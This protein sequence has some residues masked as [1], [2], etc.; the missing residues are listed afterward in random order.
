M[1]KTE[2]FIKFIALL[3]NKPREMMQAEYEKIGSQGDPDSLASADITNSVLGLWISR[4]NR[5]PSNP[6][7]TWLEKSSAPLITPNTTMNPPAYQST[8]LTRTKSET[9]LTYLT[10]KSIDVSYYHP[11]LY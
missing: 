3:V 2:C 10:A 6:F 11:P 4:A 1:A 7:P 5:R 9:D 8:P